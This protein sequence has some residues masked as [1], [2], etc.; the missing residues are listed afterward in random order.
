MKLFGTPGIAC[1]QVCAG[2]DLAYMETSGGY[3]FLEDANVVAKVRI[4]QLQELL[5][6]ADVVA[7]LNV[8]MCDLST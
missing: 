4:P 1:C 6:C 3:F 7:L 2:T 5:A 8:N